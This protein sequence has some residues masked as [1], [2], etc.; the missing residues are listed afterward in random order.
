MQDQV[1]STQKAQRQ[2]P[3]LAWGVGLASLIKGKSAHTERMRGISQGGADGSFP[4]G[5]LQGN[6]GPRESRRK[7]RRMRDACVP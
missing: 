6:L 7:D 2:R 3:Q 5:K 4:Q 1:K